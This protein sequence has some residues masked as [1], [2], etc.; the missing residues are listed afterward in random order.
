MKSETDKMNAKAD[1]RTPFQDASL[2]I[3]ASKYQ[4]KTKTGEAVDKDIT[5]TYERVATAIAG[6][7]P[8]AK[9]TQAKKNFLWA[10]RNGAIPLAAS[11]P[12]PAPRITSQRPARLTVPSLA[13]L[14]IQ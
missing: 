3:W 6:V 13:P 7:E 2:D 1:I 8:K 14:T 4:L 11:C 5:A 9:Q 12:T 10:L